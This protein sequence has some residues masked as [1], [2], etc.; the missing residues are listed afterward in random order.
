MKERILKL[1]RQKGYNISVLKN[2]I[3]QQ[4][5]YIKNPKLIL[6]VGANIGN[7]SKEYFK[8]GAIV[9]AFEPCKHTY[10]LLCKNTK[11][12]P[13]IKKFNFAIGHNDKQGFLN[14]KKDNGHN[15]LSFHEKN[16]K[17]EKCFIF[18][19]DHLFKDKKI[20]ILKIDVEGYEMEVLKGAYKLLLKGNIKSIFIESNFNNRFKNNVDIYDIGIYLKRF[21]YKT[22]FIT[23][24]NY[25][26]NMLSHCDMF[27][28]K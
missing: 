23:N 25:K 8:T 4:L 3:S 2:P 1:I 11:D 27:F 15:S 19:L 7:Y 22:A 5:E 6:D 28:I 21:K 12:I 16:N 26:D 24:I 18:A 10:K 20:D 13:N 14:I 17:K 9:Y